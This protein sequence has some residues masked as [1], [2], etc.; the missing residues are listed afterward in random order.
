MSHT[1]PAKFYFMQLMPPWINHQYA[2]LKFGIDKLLGFKNLKRKFYANLGYNLDL[3]NPRSFNEKIHWKKLNDRN[4]LIPLTADKYRARTHLKEVLGE[5]RAQKVLIPLYQVVKDPDDINF[6]ALPDKFVIKPNH[7]SG[8]HLLVEDKQSI[9]RKT[10]IKLCKKWLYFNY[11]LYQYEWAYRH[12]DRLIIIEKMLEC[13]KGLLPMDYKF[14]CFHG[15]CSWIRVSENRFDS[16]EA[17]AYFDTAWNS[18]KINDPGQYEMETVP[19]K[20]DNLGE[21]LSLAEKLAE[22]FDAVR[23]DLFNCDGQ[24]YFG[25]IS[26]YDAS[27]M[28]KFDPESLDF[29]IGALWKIT[30]DYWERDSAN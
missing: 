3:Q 28:A 26:H 11:G 12:I 22:K 4:P 30:Q 17:Y 9:D 18:I 15:K 8:M 6:D 29:E 16:M 19:S 2:D 23:I 21:M 20:P 13:K 27:G 10:V 5:E 1:R 25:E 7:G 14:Y 24:I